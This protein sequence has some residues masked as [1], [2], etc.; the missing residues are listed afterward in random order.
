MAVE[1][2]LISFDKRGTRSWRRDWPVTQRLV[3]SSQTRYPGDVGTACPCHRQVFFK[4]PRE[5]HP[6]G[7]KGSP[8]GK[9]LDEG[10][11]GGVGYSA[12]SPSA[13]SCLKHQILYQLFP[14]PSTT[15]LA[16]GNHP[17]DLLTSADATHLGRPTHEPVPLPIHTSMSTQDRMH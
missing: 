5:D 4:G 10:S 13:D 17:P 14:S 6:D 16:E 8:D 11:I 1:V 7:V 15:G 2:E 9:T 12:Y 3:A